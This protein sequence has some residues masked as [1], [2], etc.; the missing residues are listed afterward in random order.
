MFYIKNMTDVRILLKAHDSASFGALFRKERE[1][2]GKTQEDIAR[3]L[4]CRRQTVAD[5]ERGANVGIRTMFAAL[6]A[7]GKAVELVDGRYELDRLPNF[8]EDD[9]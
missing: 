4:K 1:K 7:L 6:S 2:L 3:E 8:M 9:N 5:L